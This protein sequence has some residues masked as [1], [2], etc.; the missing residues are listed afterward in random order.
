MKN[1]I[2]NTILTAFEQMKRETLHASEALR[3]SQN[4]D[5]A[6]F[7]KIKWNIVDI[8]EKMYH[9]SVKQIKDTSISSEELWLDAFEKQYLGF[10]NK[11]PSAWVSHLEKCE[12]HGLYN[13]AH[14]EKIKIETAATLETFVKETIETQREN[15]RR[16]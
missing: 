16:G 3:A 12:K 5:E 13:E 1:L 7:Y 8:F 11:I 15:M 9:A 4:E 14:I 10:F 2:E 6:N